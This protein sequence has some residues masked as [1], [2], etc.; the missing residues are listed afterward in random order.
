MFSV[1][2]DGSNGFNKIY[3][4]ETKDVFVKNKFPR[5]WP[6]PKMAKITR[7]K[8]L[9]PVERFCQKKWPSAIWK[10]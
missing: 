9:I 7:T 8:M 1:V 10:L 5:K 2:E 3:V 6:I 4:R